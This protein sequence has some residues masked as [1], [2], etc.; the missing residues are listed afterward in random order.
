MKKL[1]K[2]LAIVAIAISAC[3]VSQTA[4]AQI[5]GYQ[6]GTGFGFGMK[7]GRFGNRAWGRNVWGG[8]PIAPTPRVDEPPFFALYPPVYYS[9]DIV[10]RPYGVSP[11]AAPPGIAPVEMG[12]PAMPL[13]QRNPYY[14]EPQPEATTPPAAAE[15]TD[16]KT[17]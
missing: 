1:P 2:L 5:E 14:V 4:M 10:Y 15:E 13:I 9:Q 8:V 6:F 11:Y 17:T 7:N 12:V 3:A 16:P